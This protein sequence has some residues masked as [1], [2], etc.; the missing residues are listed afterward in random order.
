[1]SFPH[2]VALHLSLTTEL[3]EASTPQKKDKFKDKK[4]DKS[5]DKKK[6]KSKDKKK[7][8]FAPFH[9]FFLFHCHPRNPPKLSSSGHQCEISQF[10]SQSQAP[11]LP[12]TNCDTAT[13][14]SHQHRI[15]VVV[16]EDC[17][18]T[19]CH[20]QQMVDNLV[21]PEDK[22]PISAS[23]SAV[24]LATFSQYNLPQQEYN[25]LANGMCCTYSTV[26]GCLLMC[27]GVFPA[28]WLKWQG[29]TF[30]LHF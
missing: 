4:K 13:T 11:E 27:N 1:M 28:D 7:T 23:A 6:D 10:L 16:G 14:T 22:E 5:K 19:N 9:P 15:D 26:A 21:N 20:L 25:K 12:A 29:K 24:H 3:R 18:T 8:K 17:A 30:S 2:L